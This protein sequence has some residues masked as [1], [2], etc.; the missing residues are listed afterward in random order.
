MP[1][2]TPK[3]M[4]YGAIRLGNSG[5]KISKIVLECM[6]YGNPNWNGN[7]VLGEEEALKHIKE[8]YDLGINAFDTA[9]GYSNGESEEILGRAVNKLAL[10]REEIVIMTKLCGAVSATVVQPW[11]CVAK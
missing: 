10:P 7:W 8:A 11:H 5:L 9:N 4:Q 2:T 6:T 1:T 3:N